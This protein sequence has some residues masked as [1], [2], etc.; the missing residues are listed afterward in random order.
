H[1]VKGVAI[2]FLKGYKYRQGELK[3]NKGDI[4]LYYTDGIT[5]S[6]NA[7][8]ELFGLEKLKEVVLRNKNKKAEEIKIAILEEINS[9]RGEYEQVDDLTFVILKNNE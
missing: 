4:V 7:K 1:F 2:G 3:L 9:F 6:E 8:K 5:E